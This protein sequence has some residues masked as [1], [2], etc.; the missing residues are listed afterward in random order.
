VAS[1]FFNAGVFQRFKDKVHR[2]QRESTQLRSEKTVM[3]QR[4]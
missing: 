3:F 4:N 1:P 2:C